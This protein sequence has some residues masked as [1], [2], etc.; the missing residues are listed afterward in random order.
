[1]LS[2]CAGILRLGSLRGEIL[3]GAHKFLAPRDLGCHARVISKN[4]WKTMQYLPAEDPPDQ[5]G[6]P[7]GLTR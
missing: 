2:R 7:R 5:K 3:E 4:A 6:R 1:M